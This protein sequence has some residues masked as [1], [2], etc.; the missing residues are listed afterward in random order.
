MKLVLWSEGDLIRVVD[1]ARLIAQD[2]V[3]D[4][5]APSSGIALDKKEQEWMQRIRQ[6]G[7]A[8]T[9][10]LHQAQGRRTD[11]PLLTIQDYWVTPAD[12]AQ[13]LVDDCGIDVMLDG[14]WVQKDAVAIHNIRV[15]HRTRQACLRHLGFRRDAIYPCVFVT[16]SARPLSK[17]A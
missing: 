1:V 4:D 10:T 3:I 7:D 5:G 16:P 12:L 2:I 13:W 8:K 9:L 15:C 6:A 17:A 14:K 11:N